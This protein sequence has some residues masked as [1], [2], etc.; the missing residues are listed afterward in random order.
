[1][2]KYDIMKKRYADISDKVIDRLPKYYRVLGELYASGAQ[3]VSSREISELLGFTAS[4]V[5]QD[6]SNFG[7]FGQQGYGYDTQNLIAEIKKILGLNRKFSMI[8]VGAGK[9]GRA[10]SGYKSF[11]KEGFSVIGVFDIQE[12]KENGI[13]SI[14]SLESFAAGNKVDIAVLAVPKDAAL[15][16]AARISAAGIKNFWN[17]APIDLGLKDAVVENINMSESLF[18]L[19]YRVNESQM[20]EK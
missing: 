11:E 20:G 19:G 14:D 2:L 5:R 1:M 7:G 17:F 16:T 12:D 15:K 8:I 13:L 4:Q 10:L 3:K 6:L 9:I 18:K